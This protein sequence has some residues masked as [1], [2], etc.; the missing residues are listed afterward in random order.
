MGHLGPAPGEIPQRRRK[1]HQ[2]HQSRHLLRGLYR[3]PSQ[4]HLSFLPLTRLMVHLLEGGNERGERRGRPRGS[5][6][7]AARRAGQRMEEERGGGELRGANGDGSRVVADQTVLI[8][9]ELKRRL[10]FRPQKK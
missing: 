1:V 3:R 6:A 5:G 4:H 7:K 9:L 8:D 10:G 2:V